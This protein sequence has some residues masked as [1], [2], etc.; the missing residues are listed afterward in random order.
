MHAIAL[1]VDPVQ[2]NESASFRRL[3]VA[4]IKSFQEELAMRAALEVAP[5]GTDEQYGLALDLMNFPLN[6][7]AAF[8]RC[9]LTAQ[10]VSISGPVKS[11]LV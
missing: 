11:D 10:E 6:A 4:P 7:A 1:L 2:D 5:S 3:N 9:D 8:E